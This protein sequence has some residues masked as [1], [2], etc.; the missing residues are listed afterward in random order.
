MCLHHP[1]TIPQPLVHG[2]TVIQ[3]GW[4]LLSYVIHVAIAFIFSFL[5]FSI[6]CILCPSGVP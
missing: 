4:G 6:S 5:F 3:E 1:E 2:D